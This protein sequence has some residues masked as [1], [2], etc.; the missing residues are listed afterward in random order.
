M[1]DYFTSGRTLRIRRLKSKK[2][3]EFPFRLDM[4]SVEY[5]LSKSVFELVFITY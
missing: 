1:I 5:F 3:N 4:L 2:R